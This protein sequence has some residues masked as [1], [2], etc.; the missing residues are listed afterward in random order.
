LLQE[1][2]NKRP[3]A[4]SYG[5]CV[6]PR[7]AK[8][9]VG[10]VSSLP[11][12]HRERIKTVRVRVELLGA[13]ELLQKGVSNGSIIYQKKARLRRNQL[14]CFVG[15]ADYQFV[16]GRQSRQVGARAVTGPSLR[17]RRPEKRTPPSFYRAAA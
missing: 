2:P 6:F 16:H 11:V 7:L 5:Q 17:D 13:F 10:K 4:V 8:H 12:C 14:R 1:Q 9:H 15:K 3:L